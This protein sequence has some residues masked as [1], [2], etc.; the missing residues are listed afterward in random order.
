MYMVD[1]VQH[2]KDRSFRKYI[3]AQKRSSERGTVAEKGELKTMELFVKQS[4]TSNCNETVVGS[5]STWFEDPTARGKALS[6]S[7]PT[8]RSNISNVSVTGETFESST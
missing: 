3:S 2:G 8:I 4:T 6:N 7:S 5:T 1:R